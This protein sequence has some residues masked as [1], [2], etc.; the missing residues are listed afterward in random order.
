MLI[1]TRTRDGVTIMDFSGEIT[2]GDMALRKAMREVLDAGAIKILLNFSGVTGCDYSSGLDDLIGE[3]AGAH[4]MAANRGARLKL[5]NL[6]PVFMNEPLAISQI[7]TIFD[8]FD[9]EDEGVK[10]FA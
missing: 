2:T 8:V 6:P 4:T 10:S 9:S 5:A 3:L 1:K 7:L